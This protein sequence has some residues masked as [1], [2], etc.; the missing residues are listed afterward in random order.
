MEG[1][2]TLLFFAGIAAAVLFFVGYNKLQRASQLVREAA[3]NIQV[4]LRKK[5]ELTQ[6]AMDV[7]KGYADHEKLVHLK[8]SSDMANSFK[9][10]ANANARAEQALAYVS[11]LASRFPELKADTHF[12]SLNQQLES[13]G[14][15][16]QFKRDQYNSNVRSYNTNRT[17]I[18]TVFVA[19]ALKFPEAPYLDFEGGAS[20]DIL[21]TFQTDDGARLEAF[22]GNL[23]HRV[24]DGT[25]A[26][27]GK[28]AEVSSVVASKARSTGSSAV[29]FGRDRLGLTQY[30]Y[31]EAGVTKGPITRKELDEM[32]K[33]K[34]FSPRGFILEEGTKDWI[35]YETLIAKGAPL[36][37]PPDASV[38][39]P[40][41]AIAQKN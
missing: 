22:L 21:Q 11:Q 16:L 29:E 26:A 24:A 40:P 39:P 31:S 3:S 23:G 17:T 34:K 15:Q 30:H 10:L 36:P 8:V 27:V 4:M 2:I 32:V 13:L 35:K 14:N 41:D 28:A 37:P 20:L 12:A 33:E 9:D 25:K 7:C 38:P 18:P 1:L 19:R 6:Q 5:L